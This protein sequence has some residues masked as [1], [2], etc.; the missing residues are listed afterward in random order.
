MTLTFEIHEEACRGCGICA[1]VC[2]TDV[3]RMDD[4]A[5]KARLGEIEDCIACLSCA[6][7]CPS[8]AIR[9]GGYHAVKNFYRDL[10][11]TA[12]MERIL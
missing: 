12:R 7:A 1:E 8:G 11:F 9:H 5:A 6:Y 3:L 2:P 4:E 10:H